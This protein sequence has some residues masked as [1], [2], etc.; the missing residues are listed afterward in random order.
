MCSHRLRQRPN[1]G[2]AT[3]NIE[4]HMQAEVNASAEEWPAAPSLV[5]YLSRASL[6]FGPSST[7]CRD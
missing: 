6:G 4:G 2:K 5:G 1:P 3:N 7:S